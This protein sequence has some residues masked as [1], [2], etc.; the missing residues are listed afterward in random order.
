MEN[1]AI[2]TNDEFGNIRT[3]E[4]NG[5]IY[6]CGKDVATALGYTN[7]RDALSKHC[8]GVA[9]RDV[10]TTSG[11][12]SMSFV[13]EGD[14]YRLIT[15][16][17]L[18]TAEKFE[19]WVFDEVLPT[20]RSTGRYIAPIANDSPFPVNIPEPKD[21][22]MAAKLIAHCPKD[23]LKTVMELLRN[24][25]FDI[26]NKPDDLFK[27]NTGDI[28]ERITIVINRTGL[29]VREIAEFIG[30]PTET[31]RSYYVQSRYP[32]YDRYVEIVAGLNDILSRYEVTHYEQA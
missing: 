17:K 23:R 25:G 12:Q 1:L 28:S 9:K 29:N 2:F 16:S 4:E 10:P 22:L 13:P 11:V 18:P 20:I 5:K 8:K 7:H 31:L 26:K 27:A 15:H 19:T 6:F 30:M 32:R 3:I 21:Y 14:L 24:G